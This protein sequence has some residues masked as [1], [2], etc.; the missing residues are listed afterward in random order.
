MVTPYT[1]EGRFVHVPPV[2]PRTDWACNFGRPWWREDKYYIGVLSEKTRKIRLI[3]TLTLEEQVVEVCAEET[4]L[5]IMQR[6][7]PYNAHAGS[8]VWKYFGTN[9]DMDKTL[10]ENG[11][12]DESE[13]FYEL[14]MDED[15]FIPPITL[16]F[17]DDLTEF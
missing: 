10:E 12:V 3:N 4:M 9:M 6:Y 14:G 13:D 2:G 1:P 16:H 11:V 17:S 15:E 5:E 8:Y 7:T